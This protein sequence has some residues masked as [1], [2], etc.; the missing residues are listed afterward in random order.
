MSGEYHAGPERP[1]R[2]FHV[3][4]RGD[5]GRAGGGRGAR[6]WGDL[7]ARSSACVALDWEWLYSAPREFSP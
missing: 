7:S 2:P 4:D 5:R 3:A 1:C 6:S